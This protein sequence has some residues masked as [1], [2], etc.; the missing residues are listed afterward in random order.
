MTKQHKISSPT[1]DQWE[2]KLEK[3]LAKN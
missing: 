2:K 1:L 3:V